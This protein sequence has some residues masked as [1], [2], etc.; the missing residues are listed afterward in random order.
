M[1]Q[2]L[3]LIALAIP[4]PSFATLL[5]MVALEELPSLDQQQIVAQ[6]TQ[7]WG[8]DLD[9]ADIKVSETVISMKIQNE[10]IGIVLID[11]PIP[12]AELEM[13]CKYSPG[14]ET[15]TEEMQAHSSQMIATIIGERSPLL[16]R[17]IL[18]TK[19]TA[20]LLSLSTSIG[21]YVGH[22][23]LVRSK[24]EYLAESERLRN[25][26]LP[27]ANWVFF[28][29]VE[30][31]KGNVGF[32]VGLKHFGYKEFEVMESSQSLNDIYELFYNTSS[33]VIGNDVVFRNKET[34]GYTASQKIPIRFKKSRVGKGKAI[35]IDF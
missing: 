7:D 8:M 20:S 12:W 10:I 2:L 30:T 23:Q 3:L 29:V 18:L 15:A 9:T 16:K 31:G 26:D 13:P 34:I 5:T 19:V 21:V 24:T 25:D 17:E 33:Y 27:I 1:K 4:F 14:W 6:L 32:T 28:G 35:L 11:V 22:S